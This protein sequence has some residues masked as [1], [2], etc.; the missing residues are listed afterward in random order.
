MALE[1]V[2]RMINDE[3]DGVGDEAETSA[4]QPTT[5]ERLRAALAVRRGPPRGTLCAGVGLHEERRH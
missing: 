2:M 4:D 3:L 1:V 5:K